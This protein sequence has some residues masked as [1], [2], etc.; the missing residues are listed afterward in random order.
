MFSPLS[1]RVHQPVHDRIGLS[2]E[3]PP[4]TE[5]A[6]EQQTQPLG[7]TFVGPQRPFRPPSMGLGEALEHLDRV[8]G[9]SPH[10][11]D[12]ESLPPVRDAP[13]QEEAGECC[14]DFV[15]DG[16]LCPFTGSRHLVQENPSMS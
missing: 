15:V 10:E 4:R 8:R 13:E 6:S 11:R 2:I 16:P 12:Q 5:Q 7:P 14:R 9:R 3:N 1:P